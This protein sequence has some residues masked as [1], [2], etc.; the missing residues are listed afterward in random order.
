M[1]LVLSGIA[2]V[3]TTAAAW[4]ALLY[5]RTARRADE[6]LEVVT[7]RLDRAD[8]AL[9]AL[10]GAEERSASLGS[11]LEAVPLGVIVAGP[12]GRELLRNQAASRLLGNRPA[13]ALAT[14]AVTE[15]MAAAAGGAPASRSLELFGPPR[16]TLSL[17]G[18]TLPGGAGAVIVEDVSERGRLEAV[19][20]DFVANVSHELKTPVAAL[21]LLAETLAAEDDLA[22]VRRLV[23]R[24]QDEAF[25][26]NHIIDDLLDL[27]RLE[28]E[29]TVTHEPVAV[30]A[31]VAEAVEHVRRA[32]DF[33]EVR[34]LVG[35]IPRSWNLVGDRR[36]LVSAFAN[37][38]EN[39]VKYSGEGSEVSV[40]AR[41]DGST[42]SLEVEDHGIGIPS[43]E[44]DRIFERFYRVDRGRG[45]GTGGTG[46]GLS[47]VR[48]IATNH[49]GDVEVSSVEGEGSTFTLVLPAEARPMGLVAEAG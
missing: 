18:V 33:R 48:H 17:T 24:M 44:L 49:G 47:I 19:R 29:P 15:V 12:G 10:A 6:Q 38:L 25:R 31:V 39:A 41:T 4:F 37:L 9:A 5:V 26:V 40:R 2:L 14:G 20:R 21:G 22:V 8:T 3:A 11:T 13:D 46:L 45:R 35:E 36:Q 43:R 7:K 32:A 34:I 23:G 27:S 30:G 16:R 1:E 28:G 42:I